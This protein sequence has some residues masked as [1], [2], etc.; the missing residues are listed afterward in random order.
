MAVVVAIKI[1]ANVIWRA[2]QSSTSNRWIAVCEPMNLVLE[3]DSVDELRSLI[4][5]TTH[6][7]ML[8]LLEDNELEEFLRA[9]GWSAVNFPS[10]KPS[11]G[12][13]FDVPWELLVSGNVRDSQHK[14]H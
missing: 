6:M 8:N 1:Q 10:K 2:K 4:N 11:D 3:G 12:V 14:A 5:E 7:L 13:E 9:R